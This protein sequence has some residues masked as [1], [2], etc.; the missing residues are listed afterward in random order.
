MLPTFVEIKHLWVSTYVFPRTDWSFDNPTELANWFSLVNAVCMQVCMYGCMPCMYLYCMHFHF[1]RYLKF[2]LQPRHMLCKLELAAIPNIPELCTTK[3][4]D[5]R[6]FRNP[7]I[8]KIWNSVWH[9]FS[10]IFH[11][12]QNSR[13]SWFS[14]SHVLHIDA[15]L[16]KHHPTEWHELPLVV[17]DTSSRTKDEFWQVQF[18]SQAMMA[19]PRAPNH[20]DIRVCLIKPAL[21]RETNGFQKPL[22]SLLWALFLGG[23][24]GTWKGG[25]G[26]LAKKQLQVH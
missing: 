20:P 24:E 12:P 22:I 6:T 11:N 7:E 18:L 8:F 2:L 14:L 13:F 25:G 17:S 10:D 16:G 9:G 19:S 4:N 15:R 5:P 1:G 23:G 3:S 26:W 21:F